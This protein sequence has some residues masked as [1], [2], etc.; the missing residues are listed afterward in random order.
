MSPLVPISVK[1]HMSVANV[2]P[3]LE[4]TGRRK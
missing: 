2:T 4:S 1:A 3:E